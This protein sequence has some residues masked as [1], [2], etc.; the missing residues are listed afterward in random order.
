MIGALFRSTRKDHE[1]SEVIVVLTPQV[2]DDSES[3]SDFGYRY[4]PSPETQEFLDKRGY[5]LPS[6]QDEN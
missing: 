6:K 4:T 3:N 5:K 1:R 2:I